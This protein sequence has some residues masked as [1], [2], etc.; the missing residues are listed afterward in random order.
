M[1]LAGVDRHSCNAEVDADGDGVPDV[2]C[3]VGARSGTGARPTELYLTQANGSL[4]MVDASDH[5]LGRFPSMRA[6]H[7]A[8]LR[9]ADGGQLVLISTQG[10]PR[11]DDLPNEHRM[12]RLQPPQPGREP[13]FTWE[14]GPWETHFDANGCLQIADL[15]G[16]GVDDLLMCDTGKRAG[17]GHTKIFTQGSDGSW[18]DWSHL[19]SLED[20]RYTSNWRSAT[21]ADV[22]GD[23]VL[24]AV[25]TDFERDPHYVR[26]FAGLASRAP[27]FF[28]FSQPYFERELPHAA[29]DVEVFDVN[30]DDV[31]DMCK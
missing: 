13:L 26:V 10:Q 7:I 30:G 11:D 9:A 14:R 25:V 8:P 19:D 28:D 24:D 18:S 23:G 21:I 17:S 20:S 27:P 29:P 1:L 15:D 4:R 6:R 3:A 5:G 12:F 31:L 16:N 22:T 2:I